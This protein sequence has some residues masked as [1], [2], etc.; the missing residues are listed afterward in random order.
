MSLKL[1]MLKVV[2]VTS[3]H[4]RDDIRVFDKQCKGLSLAGLNVT[5]VVFDGLGDA[6]ADG[7]TIV[8]LGLVR[9]RLMRFLI[10]PLKAYRYLSKNIDDKTIIQFHDPEMLLC[11]R[12][13]SSNHAVVF[14]SHEHTSLQ[15][16]ARDWLPKFIRPLVSKVY[17]IFE[18]Y[19]FKKLMLVITPQE[20]MTQEFSSYCRTITISNYP[21][22]SDYGYQPDESDEDN[23]RRYK[24]VYAGSITKAR[25]FDNMISLINQLRNI[26]PKYQLH[27]AGPISEDCYNHLKSNHG[28]GSW[29]FYHGMLDQINLRKLYSRSGIGLI[30][31]EPIGQYYMANSLKVFEYM[32]SRHVLVVPDFGEWVEFNE[33]HRVGFP[34]KD[35]DIFN[36]AKSIDRA[37]L[38]KLTE[39]GNKNRATVCDCFSWDKE[40]ERLINAYINILEVSV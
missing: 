31:F 5:L 27:L 2:H 21:R 23:S 19:T 34:F 15:I 11:G 22:I 4:N 12:L 9:S 14:D 10:C 20:S 25:G 36:L 35:N 28:L 40:I 39:L 8:D 33:K 1:S 26:N 3:A 17:S 30:M 38:E 29:L 16:L 18:R 13:L 24:L 7:V 6:V 32:L 37:S